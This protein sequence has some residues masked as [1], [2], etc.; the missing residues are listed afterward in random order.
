M[1]EERGKRVKV[2]ARDD[3]REVVK[4]YAHMI[5]GI[6]HIIMTKNAGRGLG[7]RRDTR[8]APGKKNREWVI[9][10]I[11]YPILLITKYMTTIKRW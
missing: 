10:L 1:A 9:V 11:S 6:W 5:V 7:I 4:E 3:R 8:N 2:L